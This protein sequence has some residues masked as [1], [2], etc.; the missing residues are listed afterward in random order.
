MDFDTAFDSALESTGDNKKR[1][2]FPIIRNAKRQRVTSTTQPTILSMKGQFK[3]EP[4]LLVA[5]THFFN[6]NNQ[7]KEYKHVSPW[8]FPFVQS[9]LQKKPTINFDMNSF[10]HVGRYRD[11]IE[12]VTRKYEESYLTDASGDQRKCVN[13]EACEGLNVCPD[14]FI[15]RE[16]LLPSQQVI[17]DETKRYPLNREPCIMCKRL[18]IAR[19]VIAIR[20]AGNGMKEDHLIQDYYNF[21]DLEGEYRLED[22][23]LSKKNTWEGL[24]NPVVLHQR[25]NYQFVMQNKRKTYKQWRYPFFRSTLGETPGA[26]THS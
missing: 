8:H 1:N 6:R 9:L 18:R 7:E 2:P 19:A 20:A 17:Y 4:E 14:G 26:I 3:L 10:S 25:H 21:V 15:L 12:G 13:E 22:C 24:C 23:L 11:S 5:Q 16:F